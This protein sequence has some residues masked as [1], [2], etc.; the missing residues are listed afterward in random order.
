MAGNVRTSPRLPL[1]SFRR[2]QVPV[3]LALVLLATASWSILL[4]WPMDPM[5]DG[6]TM[7]LGPVMFLLIWLVMMVAMMFPAATPMIAMFTRLASERRGGGQ[8]FV[9]TWLFVSTYLVVW[10]LFG[11]VVS[12]VAVLSEWLISLLSLSPATI[13]R[14]GG[15]LLLT[16]GVYQLTPLK[17]ACLTK[18]RSPFHF[19]LA[20][21]RDG[22]RGALALGL[23]HGLSCLGCCWMLFVLLLPLGFMN[24]GAMAL[25]TFLIVAEK[26]LPF[27]R[28]ARFTG[29]TALLLYGTLALVRPE[30]LPTKPG[31]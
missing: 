27:G 12:V 6:L 23:R 13:A 16:A 28:I 4:R 30:L 10:L 20:H 11:V 18:C 22:Y 19:L 7:G 2:Q 21:W 1:G 9:P 15:V 29:A 17:R 31:L 8:P 3:I 14:F 24:I 26:V 5:S 25:V